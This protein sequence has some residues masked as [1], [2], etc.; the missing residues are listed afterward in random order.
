MSEN[1]TPLAVAAL[2]RRRAEIA[3]KIAD[4]E[5]QIAAL[6]D[7]LLHLD[8]TLRPFDPNV[9]PRHIPPKHPQIRSDG[10]FGRGEI[11][12]RIYDALRGGQD[13]SAVDI[14]EMA[15]TAK[16]LPLDDRHLSRHLHDAVP[17]AP[18]P[19]CRQTHHRAH[20]QRQRR[21][22]ARCEWGLAPAASLG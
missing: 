21:P 5:A 20:R 14:V 7:D 15:M 12:R 10:Y 16:A 4:L 9:E 1:R 8:H 19:A 22:M 17:G 2:I 3:G 6:R 11:T 18:Q 13:V